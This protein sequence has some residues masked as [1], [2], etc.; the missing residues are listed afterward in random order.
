[1]LAR[2]FI[3]RIEV[4]ACTYYLI[5]FHN[6]EQ[7]Y[8]YYFCELRFITFLWFVSTKTNIYNLDAH[9]ATS[10]ECNQL[11]NPPNID[12]SNTYALHTFNTPL[13]L[14]ITYA[15][16]QKST[17][18]IPYYTQFPVLFFPLSIT[19]THIYQQLDV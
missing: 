10:D 16:L 9:K 14:P 15:A 13:F 19:E 5:Q 3:I 7:R 2:S 8:Q 6:T 17:L 4:C 11:L 18:F 1:M 12:I